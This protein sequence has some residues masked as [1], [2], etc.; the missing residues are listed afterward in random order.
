MNEEFSTKAFERYVSDE[1]SFSGEHYTIHGTWS[2]W[3]YLWEY[4]GFL[5]TKYGPVEVVD[6]DTDY[7][8]GGH[9]RSLVVKIGDRHFLKKGYYDSWDS[10]DWDGSIT[11][12][13]PVEKTVV[14]YETI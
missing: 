9:G 4:S 2:F 13:K 8:D 10:Y 6:A 5:N 12:V 7:D 1:W 3:N 11:E 14:V